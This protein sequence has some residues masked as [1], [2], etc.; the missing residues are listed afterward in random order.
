MN[1]LSFDAARV[2][3]LPARSRRRPSLLPRHRSGGEH[4]PSVS[5]HNPYWAHAAARSSVDKVQV[6]LTQRAR[7]GISITATS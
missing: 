2:C 7:G 4:R 6:T 3:D 5:S 1:E